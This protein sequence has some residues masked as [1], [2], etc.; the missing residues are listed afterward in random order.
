MRFL[1]RYRGR[2]LLGVVCLLAT[3]G[4]AQAIPWV[5]KRT[6]ETMEQGA[7]SHRIALLAGIMI[8][9]AVGQALI[10][11]ASRVTIFNAGRD[12][13]FKL[14]SLLFR[15][16]CQL[17]GSFF[18]RLRTGE[19]M[20]R[21]TND[22]A[23]VRGLFGP[24]VL[25]ATNTLFAYAFALPL[26]LRIDASLT[27]LALLPY[28]LLL[29]GARA[30]A[31]GVYARSHSQQRT[32]AEMTSIVQEDLAGIRELKN[33][34]LEQRRS[35]VF[36]DASQ[37]YLSE[38][39]R[40][41]VWRSCMLPF[42]G[43]GA[44]MSLVL[45]LWVGGGRV[46]SGRLSLG[47]LVAMNLYVGLLAW[48]TMAIGWMVA[49]W[50]RGVA[51]WHRLADISRARPA[52]VD[53]PGNAPEPGPLRLDVR[54]L[55]VTMG[56]RHIVEN[57]SFTIAPG[58]ICAVVG[59]VGSG[60]STLVEAI[61]RLVPIAPGCIFWNGVDI[62]QL[63]LDAVRRQVAYAPQESFLFSQTLRENIA[64][65]AETPPIDQS[66]AEAHRSASLP[67]RADDALQ[68]GGPD[69]QQRIEEAVRVAGL[70]PDIEAL[71]S[72]LDTLVGERGVSLSGGQ[73]QRV[74][75]ARALV[76]HRPLLILDDS[77][78]AVDAETERKILHRL[79]ETLEDTTTLLTSHRLSALQHAD[80]IIVLDQGRVAETGSHADLLARG[81]VYAQLYRKQLLTESAPEV[82]S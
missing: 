64:F 54:Q 82:A 57:V 15:H 75:L 24:G 41:A 71:P 72:G 74:A 26:M 77:L 39:L 10:R 45:V 76:A 51:G 50:Q 35:R 58:S 18:L 42:V 27:L 23:A 73:R 44:G 19:L 47:D 37:R 25:H 3:N 53:G 20:S 16:L 11:I 4:L 29:L 67:T 69:L 7:G 1:A 46:I 60:K 68:E 22:L 9:L 6:I 80:L 12:A 32:L 63:R 38:A 81:G 56:D 17:D 48:P 52:L 13:E 30:F 78:S 61:A 28:P 14:R 5:V 31:H 8:A 65:G 2:V 49:V 43:A 66:F 40:L 59:K 62:T 21:L 70:Q 34:G 36:A 55:H 79:R 33:Y